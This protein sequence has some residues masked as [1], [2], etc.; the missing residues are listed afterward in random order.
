MHDA[1]PHPVP[2]S[3]AP[4]AGLTTAVAA[5]LAG[6]L[7]SAPLSDGDAVMHAAIGRWMVRHGQLLPTPDPLVWTDRGGDHQHEWLAQ[8][9]IGAAVNAGGL[10][11]LRVLGGLLAAVCAVLL[12]RL[13][14]RHG[15]AMG[16]VVGLWLLAVQPHLAPRPHLLGWTM[17]VAVL[18]YGVLA[19][20]PWTRR[21]ALGWLAAGALWANLH[22]SVLIAPVYAALIA[23]DRLLL[24]RMAKQPLPWQDSL[25]RV[26]VCGVATLLQPLGPQLAG[27]VWQSQQIGAGLSDEW[28]PLLAPD[29]VAGQPFALA[30]WAVALILLALAARQVWRGQRPSWPGSLAGTAAVLHA[31][32]TRRMSV[33]LFLP[34]LFGAQALPGKPWLG[35][36]VLAGA[37]AVLLPRVSD[38]WTAR[39]TRQGAFPEA[40]TAFLQR[41]H[42][43]G[44]VFN[45]DPWGGWL[46]W[47]LSEPQQTQ[48]FLDGRLLLGGRQVAEDLIAMQVRNLHG[49][50]LLTRYDIEVLIQRTGDYLQVPPPD[51][52]QW[53]LAWRDSQA[54]VLVRKGANWQHNRAGAAAALA[55]SERVRRTHWPQPLRGPPGVATP[56]D[57]RSILEAGPN[58]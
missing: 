22:S 6:L 23:A 32:V 43:R 19:P 39:E 33:F 9:L 7:G 52:N 1:N 47:N 12:S 3:P 11:S 56:T 14:H 29:V 41:A 31:A 20:Q 4:R 48:V 21:Q 18:G 49:Q 45:P 26:G 15:A 16:A 58:P 53:Y 50:E 17:A 10:G 13:A 54:V 46:A 40:A 8:L 55:E 44:R 36:G 30:A 42:L 51:P 27:Y 25:V 34:L 5:L 37:A 35:A 28:L 38:V 2:R 57:V 24:A